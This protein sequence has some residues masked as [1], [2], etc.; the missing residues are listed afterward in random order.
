MRSLWKGAITF[1]LVNIPVALYPA[2]TRTDLSFRQLH[3]KDAAP[4]AYRRVC[5]A[6]NV[7]VPWPEIVKGY[8]YAKGEFVVMTDEDFKNADADANQTIDI[9]DFVPAD[10]ID[11]TYFEQPYYLEPT[12]TGAK[13]YALLREA[14]KRS[15]RVGIATF[16]LRQ[17][18][19][20][21]AVKVADDALVLTTMR[22]AHEIVPATELN[23]PRGE[24]SLDKREVDLA[25]QLVDTLAADWAP[26]K[27][28][29][30]YR[31]AL[32]AA[33]ERKVEGRAIAAPAAGRKPPT[34]VVDLMQ[35]LQAS[36]EARAPRTAGKVGR[37]P[38]APA[39]RPAAAR[40]RAS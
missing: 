29:D 38:A 18:E 14:L 17:R 8:E 19:H 28:R 6:E 20:L 11:F 12:A 5:T 26:D 9:R 27:Y 16:V 21:A 22:F 25:L 24:A 33:I 36:L 15:G 37:K 4:I 30:R 10:A 32:L 35:A 7:E 34:K 40:R 13:A 39:G 23:V 31:E 3:A 2:T 1:G